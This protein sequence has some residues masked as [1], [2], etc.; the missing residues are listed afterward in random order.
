MINPFIQTLFL[1]NP[2]Y[3]D[4]PGM[5]ITRLL[6]FVNVCPVLSQPPD[7]L[8]ITII[9]DTSRST[10]IVVP[11]VKFEH[12]LKDLEDILL[13]WK[14]KWGEINE[15]NIRN[16]IARSSADTIIFPDTRWFYDII[17]GHF[18]DIRV[19]IAPVSV[20]RPWRVWALN[21]IGHSLT[22]LNT[23]H[24]RNRVRIL[25]NTFWICTGSL[26]QIL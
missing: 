11:P 7:L 5:G 2:E 25:W 22:K 14:Q 9:K 21:H 23:K 16:F 20:K 10:F 15:L 8:H 1:L 3:S 13:Y 17:H 12:D 6:A 24:D 4:E 18:T 26:I 19:I